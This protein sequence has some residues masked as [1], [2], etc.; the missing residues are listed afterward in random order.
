M[1]IWVAMTQQ[2]VEWRMWVNGSE[3]M[4]RE[5]GT[6]KENEKETSRAH[7]SSTCFVDGQG[8]QKRRDEDEDKVETEGTRA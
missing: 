8:K 6:R 5:R 4:V 2:Q 1:I 7:E 3:E